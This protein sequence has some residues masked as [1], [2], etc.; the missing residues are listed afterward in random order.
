MEGA[1]SGGTKEGTTYGGKAYAKYAQKRAVVESVSVV[2]LGITDGACVMGF[3]EHEF[4]LEV[5]G[6]VGG[7]EH[8]EFSGVVVPAED[9]C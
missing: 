8:C 2:E 1:V 6:D 3:I 5:F 7:Y 9:G 4:L